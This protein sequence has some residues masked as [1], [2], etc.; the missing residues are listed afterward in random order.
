MFVFLFGKEEKEFTVAGNSEYKEKDRM[1]SCSRLSLWVT[2]YIDVAL[3][4]IKNKS[5]MNSS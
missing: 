3:F 1:N 4:L 5:S 2:L